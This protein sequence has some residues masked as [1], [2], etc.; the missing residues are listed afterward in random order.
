MQDMFYWGLAHC[1]QLHYIVPNGA[2]PMLEPFHGLE[3]A[4]YSM[5][6]NFDEGIPYTHES[7][8]NLNVN[9]L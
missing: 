5:L 7:V 4:G 2:H 9:D 8:R 3:H 1:D 6:S